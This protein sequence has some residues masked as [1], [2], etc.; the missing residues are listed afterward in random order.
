MLSLLSNWMTHRFVWGK[1]VDGV[2]GKRPT[3]PEQADLLMDSY[4]NAR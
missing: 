2:Q 4:D 3:R 1:K